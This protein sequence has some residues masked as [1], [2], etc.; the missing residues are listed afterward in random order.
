MFLGLKSRKK[1]IFTFTLNLVTLYTDAETLISLYTNIIKISTLY[2]LINGVK[3]PMFFFLR[4]EA[5][6]L[7]AN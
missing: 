3:F 4:A 6:L 5:T 2:P 7:N 1:G